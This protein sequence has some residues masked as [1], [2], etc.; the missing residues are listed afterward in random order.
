[1]TT[2]VLRTLAS[3]AEQ[4]QERLAHVVA[5]A[6]V[7]VRQTGQSTVSLDAAQA[8]SLLTQPIV[9]ELVSVI[10][11]AWPTP[12]CCLLCC[13]CPLLWQRAALLQRQPLLHWPTGQRAGGYQMLGSLLRPDEE[14]QHDLLRLLCTHPT[15]LSLEQMARTR[16]LATALAS[17]DVQTLAYWIATNQPFRA[18]PLSVVDDLHEVL[19]TMVRRRLII[20][21]NGGF[22]VVQP[23]VPP[24]CERS[25][26]DEDERRVS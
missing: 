26:H 20:E 18:T 25:E 14:V 21:S 2:L 3:Q 15:P 10:K 9:D 22:T 16:F 17:F 7:Q 8:E 12:A 23:T 11:A 5:Q 19:Q 1:M 4:Q 24:S 13:A 6:L